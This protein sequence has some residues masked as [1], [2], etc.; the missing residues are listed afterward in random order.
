MLYLLNAMLFV[1]AIALILGVGLVARAL[2]QDRRVESDS[3]R[4]YFALEYDRDLLQQNRFKETE[5]R[6]ADRDPRFAP[7]RFRDPRASGR[8]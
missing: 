4:G 7:F 6:L 5:G 1:G 3:L 2:L 8:R